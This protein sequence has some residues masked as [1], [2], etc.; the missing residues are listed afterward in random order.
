[1]SVVVRL[2]VCPQFCP[3]CF[4]KTIHR[5]VFKFCI[6]LIILQILKMCDVVVLIKKKNCQNSG[7]LKINE[8]LV[9]FQLNVH[10][11]P[12][13]F[14]KTVYRIFFKIHIFQNSYFE[15]VW[16]LNVFSNQCTFCPGGISKAIHRILFIF[17]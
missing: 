12:G 9:H 17:F 10:I 7:I 4:S 11:C 15:N 2:S 6:T 8:D 14:S 13:C 3:V 1:M 16:G 5:I